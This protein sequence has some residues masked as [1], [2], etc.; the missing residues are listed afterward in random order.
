MAGLD[1][2]TTL[3]PAGPGRYDSEL[4]PAWQIAGRLN[5]SYLLPLATGGPVDEGCD[6]WDSTG[7]LVATGHQLAGVRHP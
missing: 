6:V 1:A 5:G 7:R 4:D 3:R 2:A